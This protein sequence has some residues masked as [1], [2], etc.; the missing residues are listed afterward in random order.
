MTEPVGRARFGN[1]HGGH[2]LLD[3]S[4]E[5]PEELLERIRR[6]TDLPP[7]SGATWE[8][9]FAGYRTGDF[10][11]LQHTS[12]D[13]DAERSGMVATSVVV[14]SVA[15]LE[16]ISLAELKMPIHASTRLAGPVNSGPMPD[17]VGPCIDHLA[18][19]SA[20]HWIGQTSFD[21]AVEDLWGLMSPTDRA[22]LVFG[23]LFNPTSK[24]YPHVD[25]SIELYLVPNDLRSRFHDTI[26]IDAER[27][28]ASGATARAVLSGNTALA[29]Q[30]GISRPSLQQWLL[31]A[32]AQD[33][34]DRLESLDPEEARS[35]AH[36]LG[37][38]APTADHGID[39][40][41]R[42]GARLKAISPNAP[43]AH[44][45]GC[46]NLPFDQLPGLAL[47]DIVDP[48]TTE[49]FSDPSRLDDL[50]AAIA[51]LDAGTSDEFGNTLGSALRARCLAAA[52]NIIEH[53]HAAIGVGDQQ[54]FSWLVDTT[55]S[56]TIDSS[57]AA[58]VGPDS[59]AWLHDEAHK[60][61]M[62]ET[63]AAVC[64]ND[65]PIAAWEAH[66]TM[67][68]HTAASRQTARLAMRT[69]ATRRSC[70]PSW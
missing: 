13:P 70:P 61:A 2:R 60:H 54:S 52:D 68:G 41:E 25:G 58:T 59:A 29:D 3:A 38:L 47:I 27:P 23:L 32:A 5:V 67:D 34:I 10:Y 55:Q 39:A 16:D 17:G 69:E 11:I 40:K 53:I 56:S 48:W 44:I 26:V 8:P 20:V 66:L 65:D 19:G 28:P 31:I 6:Y 33:Y 64:P 43:F 7:Q 21:R 46:R 49:V 57:L 45:R 37:T 12:P 14:Y 15:G 9:F 22:N 35:C 18:S 36:L 62:P 63:H 4:P 50:G 42:I 24:P 30:L 1:S 51:A